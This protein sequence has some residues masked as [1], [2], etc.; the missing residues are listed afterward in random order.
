MLWVFNETYVDTGLKDEC[1]MVQLHAGYPM[2][3]PCFEKRSPPTFISETSLH[4]L[5]EADR[6]TPFCGG[7]TEAHGVIQAARKSLQ[8]GRWDHS[9]L[10]EICRIQRG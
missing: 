10:E 3:H 6:I 4:Q 5:N 9:E 8:S 1:Q 7:Q 2:N